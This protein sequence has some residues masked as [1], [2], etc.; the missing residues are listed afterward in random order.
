MSQYCGGGPNFYYPT[1]AILRR[2]KNSTRLPK[3]SHLLKKTF[4]VRVMCFWAVT[5]TRFFIGWFSGILNQG[6]HGWNPAYIYG[7]TDVVPC[8][9]K[10][11]N[12]SIYVLPMGSAS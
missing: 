9:L 2:S 4:A 5:F 1:H 8:H 3:K 6:S 10:M 11:R 12:I 7:N